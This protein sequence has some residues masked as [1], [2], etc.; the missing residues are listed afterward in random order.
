MNINGPRPYSVAQLAERW[1]CSQGLIRKLIRN[2]ELQPFTL[3]TL[4]RITAAEVQRFEAQTANLAVAAK[5]N[6]PRIIPRATPKRAPLKRP[7]TDDC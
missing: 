5:P 4:I 2:G 6:N 1:D 7:D 3:G